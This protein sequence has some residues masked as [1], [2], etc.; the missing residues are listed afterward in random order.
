M[1][2]VVIDPGQSLSWHAV[3]GPPIRARGF[4]PGPELHADRLAQGG[5]GGLCQ[6]ANLAAWLA[7]HAG[8]ELPVRHRHGLDLFPDE[9]R[10][11][12]FGLGATVFFPTRD[13][14][15]K[16]PHEVPLR[17]GFGVEDGFLLGELRFTEPLDERFVVEERDAGFERIDG[18]VYRFNRLVRVSAHGEE[19]LWSTRARVAYSVSE[20]LL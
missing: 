13:L 9:A 7:V 2:G 14:V 18:V 17:L 10:T 8:L 3:I 19:L 20:E 1:D 5:G 16:N 12:P 6:V 11:V 4:V 15:M